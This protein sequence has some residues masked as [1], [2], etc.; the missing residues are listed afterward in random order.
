M[1]LTIHSGEK[2]YLCYVTTCHTNHNF[3][4]KIIRANTFS[5]TMT[6]QVQPYDETVTS[7]QTLPTIAP[8]SRIGPSVRGQP[9]SRGRGR[10]RATS[11]QSERPRC[12]EP[13]CQKL[14]QHK[15]KDPLHIICSVCSAFFHKRC[16]S[17]SFAPHAS[18]VCVGCNPQDA[19]A[20]AVQSRRPA[21]VPAPRS[22]AP[23]SR[24][25]QSA[26]RAPAPAS[27]PSSSLPPDPVLAPGKMLNE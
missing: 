21:S 23:R 17:Q 15:R 13:T 1:S 20:S 10:G 3:N 8:F 26:S 4:N 11:L 24:P 25:L 9:Q 2:T 18:F 6:E 16:V 22:R 27:T 12:S 5:E 14:I 19:S 7:D